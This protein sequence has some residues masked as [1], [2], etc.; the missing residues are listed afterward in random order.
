MVVP[1]PE[2][3]PVTLPVINPIVQVKVL[4]RLAFSEI[5]GP[6]PLQII[7]FAA[8]VIAGVGY[9]ETVIAEAVPAHEP[10]FEVGVIIYCT[11]PLIELLGLVNV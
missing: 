1:E 9:T 4:G 2:L 7:A 5:F 11:V 10:A 6:F 8:F 3:A